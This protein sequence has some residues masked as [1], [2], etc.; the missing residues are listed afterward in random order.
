MKIV[1]VLFVL[2]MLQGCVAVVAGSAAVGAVTV[3]E[4]PRSL[5]TQIDDT[6]L[7]S[8]ISSALNDV[9]AIDQNA[10][11]DVH[12]F[13]RVVLLY[14]QADNANIKAEAERIALSLPG[15]STVQNQIRIAK[16]IAGSTAAHD[17]WL[18]SK[19]KGNLMT[20]DDVNFL[21]IDIIVEDS[22]VFLMGIVSR[23]EATKAIEIA[24]NISGVVK[25]FNLFEVRD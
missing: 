21:Q 20:S 14:G 13:N 8:D 12:V 10:N 9:P 6:T 3:S 25:V 19:V 2:S 15:V 7:A 5:G 24:R 4:D 11:I 23:T 22:E 16:S 18:S 17:L 1:F